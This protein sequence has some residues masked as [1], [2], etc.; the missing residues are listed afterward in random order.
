MHPSILLGACLALVAHA[1]PEDDA[2][3]KARQAHPGQVCSF[4]A[5]GGI[6]CSFQSGKDKTLL[7]SSDG[8]TNL[9][10]WFF[11]AKEAPAKGTEDNPLRFMLMYHYLRKG[12]DHPDTNNGVLVFRVP[13]N[14]GHI[15][16]PDLK[17]TGLTAGSAVEA[18]EM[19]GIGATAKAAPGNSATRGLYVL[20]PF[21]PTSY[22]DGEKPPE[23]K[24]GKCFTPI[25]WW[26]MTQ[27]EAANTCRKGADWQDIPSY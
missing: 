10:L 2:L 23:P 22:H 6:H 16:P 18:G 19:D 4:D 12:M 14:D 7:S 20:L 11:Q 25:L 15:E 3:E 26:G 9:E 17:A 21:E 27:D 13:A 8:H 1:G 5:G 24:V